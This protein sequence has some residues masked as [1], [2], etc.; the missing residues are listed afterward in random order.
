[1]KSFSQKLQRKYKSIKFKIK[2][3]YLTRIN[4]LLLLKDLHTLQHIFEAKKVVAALSIMTIAGSWLPV[5]NFA[6]AAGNKMVYP[7]Q[8]MS[9]LDCRFQKF[10]ELS[11]NCK[12]DLPILKTKDYKK[13]IKENG[14]YNDYTRIYT[15]L[16]ASS[17]KYWWDVWNGGHGGTDIATAEGTPVYSIYEGKVINA[18][19][20]TWWGNNVSVEHTINGKKFV[21]NYSHL[22]KINTKLWATVK[23][24]TKIGEVGNTG[25]SFGN[26][27]HFQI[28][29]DTPFHPYY[30]DYN[31]C[32]YSFSKISE[33]DICLWELTKNTIDPLA[34]L[35]SNGAILDKVNYISTSSNVS[36]NVTSTNTSNWSSS[37]ALPSILYTYVHVD[38]DAQDIKD[39]QEVY[40]DMWV[41]EWPKSGK[42]SDIKQ[43]IIAYQID[44]WV[45]ENKDSVGAWY[46][47][48][49]TRAQTQSDYREYLD[50]KD[51]TNP[52]EF[53]VTRF[54]NDSS[55]TTSEIENTIEVE[56]IS[57]TEVLTREEIEQREIDGFRKDY[58]IDLKF[59]G[60]N[61][62]IGLGTTENIVFLINKAN[63]R[64]YKWRT[65]SDITIETDESIVKVF[66]NTL[67]HFTNGKRDISVTWLKEWVTE[68][69]VKM[70]DTILKSFKVNVY[71]GKISIIP[72]S[73]SILSAKKIVF[74]EEKTG[75]VLMKDE[76]KTNL[77]N[78]RFEWEYVLKSHTD[79]KF[80]HKKTDISNIRDSL[81][82]ECDP[83]DFKD[84]IH[85]TYQDTA[86]WILVFDYKVWNAQAS[87]NLYNKETNKQLGQ[88]RLLVTQPKGLS[89]KYAYSD[90]VIDL[91]EKGIV[92]GISQWY[93]LEEREL[94]QAD[95][96]EWIKNTL[97]S[98]KDSTESVWKKAQIQERINTISTRKGEKYSYLSRRAFLEKATDYL[99]F[100][101]TIPELTIKYKDLNDDENMRANLVFDSDNTW[102]DRF[103]NNYYRPK[104]KISRWEWAYL[105]SR[106]LEKK[107]S[108]FVTL[109]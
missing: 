15:V 98:L 19:F 56:K 30:Y 76:N 39:L 104:E 49:K 34:F 41:Y 93:F 45:I 106:V 78:L 37:E 108:N 69:K 53:K 109:Q 51:F 71:N 92:W 95:A 29:L 61:G 31:K 28:D 68:L 47:W 101:D 63:G 24:W 17:Y 96:N 13:Y 58:Q 72:H 32:P 66:P 67:Y 75:F 65:P 2:I 88:K 44:R 100:D 6:K 84:E 5:Y 50:W 1:M 103:G 12:R 48:P 105:I 43:T 89:D 55:S 80:C 97:I 64:P 26:H 81:N 4:T 79:T 52:I 7:I 23:A 36:N 40:K 57:R 27:L 59:D 14:W 77:L 85:F 11:S 33:S 60:T 10:S 38:S 46:F 21:S 25:N 74:G 107:T 86:E 22:S 94:S 70:W 54:W 16:W 9:E 3:V 102:K 20:M 73:G 99:V 91:L 18:K 90:E 62:N 83:E 42:Y 87:M 82:D 8:E 35:E